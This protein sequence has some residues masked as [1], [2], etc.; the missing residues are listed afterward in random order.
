[1]TPIRQENTLRVRLRNPTRPAETIVFEVMPSL[2]ESATANYRTVDPSQAP[3]NFQVFTGSSLRAFS[4]SDIRLLAR[5][6]DEA[7]EKLRIQNLIRGWTKPYFGKGNGGSPSG[8]PPDVVLLSAYGYG[9]VVNV[10]VVIQNYQIDYPS[11]TDYIYVGHESTLNSAGS[12]GHSMVPIS[13]TMSL[14]LQEVRSMEEINNFRLEDYKAGNLG[15]R[16]T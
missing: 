16:I 9:N 13:S 3:G 15:W 7:T 2:S 1:M 4:L 11:D 6:T 12:S 8:L 14:Q 10:P 5:T